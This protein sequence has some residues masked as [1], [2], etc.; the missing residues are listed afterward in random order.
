MRSSVM[1][2]EGVGAGTVNKDFSVSS[3]ASSSPPSILAR[4]LGVSFFSSPSSSSS[5]LS[6]SLLAHSIVIASLNP[7]T[8][9]WCLFLLLTFIF[10][11]SA[12]V[13]TS[14]PLALLGFDLLE[15]GELDELNGELGV[16]YLNNLAETGLCVSSRQTDERLQASRRDW[17]SFGHVRLQIVGPELGVLLRDDLAGVLG[18]DRLDALGDVD[19]LLHER[20]RD[21]LVSFLPGVSVEKSVVFLPDRSLLVFIFGGFEV[22]GSEDVG[23]AGDG[24]HV[25]V[26]LVGAA[27]AVHADHMVGNLPVAVHIYGV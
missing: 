1:A 23:L 21:D 16:L 7:G 25:S 5:P 19:V 3:M 18:E 11:L 22:F 14:R 20:H 10:F 2:T 8:L 27:V 6:S 15:V 24:K 17:S 9:P 4:F 12:V 26:L 13:F